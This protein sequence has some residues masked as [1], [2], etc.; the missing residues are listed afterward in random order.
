MQ[1][2]AATPKDLAHYAANPNALAN[3]TDAE[4]D[5]L[6]KAPQQP[7]TA[8]DPVATGETNSSATPDA[9]SQTATDSKTTSPE[10][11]PASE[12]TPEG[13]ASR[14]GKHI[15]PFWRLA[16]AEAKAKEAADRVKAL[17]AQLASGNPA[18]GQ[19]D[20]STLLSEEELASIENDLPD[21][22]KVLRASQA[23][24]ATLSKTVSDLNA[25]RQADDTDEATRIA[26]EVETAIAAV[27]KLAHL[28][29]SNPQGWARAVELD[30]LLREK[31][32]WQDK[33]FAERFAHVVKGYE[34]VYGEI[35]APAAAAAAPLTETPEALKA[36][37]D[38]ALASAAKAATTVPRS[39]SD[40]PGGSAPPVDEVAA[41]AEKS[42]QEL[43]AYFN[44][45]TP[46]QIEA[47]LA[48]L[49]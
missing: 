23:Q 16:D 37:A 15:I 5:A 35:D 21:V 27:P 14:D 42:P 2:A 26:E 38:A 44:A 10:T 8:A 4:I 6:A 7:D 36:K 19:T 3:M 18:A 45:M 46:A 48:R 40:I 13:I 24:I 28:R 22:G 25:K 39:S 31:P 41:L 43:Q 11:P 9:A 29:E 32:E 30:T 49:P 47:K 1:Q 33:P 17:E 12:P 34:A 20:A